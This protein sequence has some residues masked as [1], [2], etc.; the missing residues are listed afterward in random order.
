MEENIQGFNKKEEEKQELTQNT[1]PQ[2]ESAENTEQLKDSEQSENYVQENF[3]ETIENNFSENQDISDSENLSDE[4]GISENESEE[5][6]S[7]EEFIGEEEEETES[8]A[9]YAEKYE[10]FSDNHEDDIYIPRDSDTE[11]IEEELGLEEVDLK[12][13]KAAAFDWVDIESTEEKI[14]P[15]EK[16][17]LEELYTRSI[18][19]IEDHQLVEA[20]VVNV[21]DKDVILNI[22]YKSDGMVPLSEFKYLDSIKPGDKVDVIVE[23][24]EGRNGQLVLSHKKARAESSWNK[25]V[26]AHENNT[27]LTGFIKDRTKGGMVVDL[28]GLDAFLPGS[29][30]D[31][32][33]VQDYDAYVGKHIDLKVVKLN[34]VYRNIVVSHKAII[35]E[36][37]E[38][39]RHSILSKLE[40][41]QV[42]E[43]VVKN[44]TSF[45]V[46][47]DLGGVD[48]LIHITDVSWGRI[49]H[50]N[51][52]LEIGQTIN[53]VV[54][55]YDEEKN[56]I[57][58]GMKQLTPH[59]WETLPEEFVEGSIIKGKVVNIE[60]YGAFIEIYPGVEGLVHV[61]EMTWSQHLKAPSDYVSLNDEVEVKILTINREE[62]KLSLGIKQLTPDPWEKVPL[63]YTKGS[64]HT[65]IIKNATN[66]GFFVELEEGIDGLVH[67]SDLSW[68]KKYNH[69]LE[70]AKIGDPI[71]VV[72]LDVDDE[73]RRLSLGHKQ[74]EEDPWE[75][76]KDIFSP[77]SIHEGTISKIDEKGATV[78]LNYGIEGFCPLKQL[79][80]END[81]KVNV[82]TILEFKV[83]EF[84]KVN[85][86][87]VLSHLAVWK[88]QQKAK[89]EDEKAEKKKQQEKTRKAISKVRASVKKSTL[90]SEQEILAELKEKLIEEESRKASARAKKGSKK[91][92]SA[93][94]E[95]S[96]EN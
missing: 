51:E 68:T 94:D 20:T 42:L 3:Q 54:L 96:S 95:Q 52:I 33:P 44:L 30:L 15:E 45:G 2:P 5:D 38:E 71:E 22:G 61:S 48:G 46:F 50:P 58:L 84:D 4:A 21:T 14:P 76:F 92:S 17:R 66:F 53:V 91:K 55:D 74:I 19:K 87:I 26:S 49:N 77:D 13:M 34:P 18:N 56:R 64:Q 67:I 41:G 1:P 32:K 73:N 62:R 8:E 70:F 47:V 12:E 16:K 24:T 10:E 36:G 11:L 88:E 60:D 93:N 75:T 35:E 39:Q 69:P 79:V 27:I 40:K 65:G 82:D 57:S 80:R 78:I 83:T 90:G 37:I 25:I 29:Q 28:L 9:T 59:P 81:Q 43:G 23:A 86:R 6:D 7:E 85:R 63:I 89:I 31:I 72:I